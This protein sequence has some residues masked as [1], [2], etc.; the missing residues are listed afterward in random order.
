VLLVSF[1]FS[2]WARI[3][4]AH[5][6]RDVLESYRLG[7]NSYVRKPVDFLELVEA[8]G[9]LGFYWLELNRC[10]MEIER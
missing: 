2:G 10:S 9:Q 1:V 6:E 3:Y 4:E 5:K 7:A 8:V